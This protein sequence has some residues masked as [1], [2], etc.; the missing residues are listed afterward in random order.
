MTLA[1]W[2]AFL[3]YSGAALALGW[4]AAGS[5][6]A[7]RDFWTAG[8]GLSGREV[9]LSLSAGFLSISWS[10]VYAVQLFYGYGAGALLLLTVPWLLALLAALACR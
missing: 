1:T 7:D 6:T 4:R 5:Q 8:R 9:G 10:C 2:I 3:A